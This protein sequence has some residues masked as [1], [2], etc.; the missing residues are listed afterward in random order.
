ML[1]ILDYGSKHCNSVKNSKRHK[2]REWVC[3]Y[4]REWTGKR[5][6]ETILVI[7]P[8]HQHC[9]LEAVQSILNSI[10]SITKT[11][12]LH[13][14]ASYNKRQ[15]LCTRIK[16]APKLSAH[17]HKSTIIYSGPPS[18]LV[19]IPLHQHCYLKAPHSTTRHPLK[20][21]HLCTRIL[22][23]TRTYFFFAT[24]FEQI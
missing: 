15:H 19:I 6:R 8:L 21:Q 2:K 16:N 10:T 18:I 14:S 5:E 20:R 22:K 17:R 24:F 1:S 4:V 7:L 9:Y 23:K 13:N 3:E 12:T 11:T